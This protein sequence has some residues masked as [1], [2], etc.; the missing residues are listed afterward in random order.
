[1]VKNLLEMDHNKRI[2][3]VTALNDKWL[4]TLTKAKNNQKK[5]LNSNVLHRLKRFVVSQ[6]IN[7]LNITV[8]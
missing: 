7:C 6:I 5:Y 4:L 8:V 3:A 1:L 2:K